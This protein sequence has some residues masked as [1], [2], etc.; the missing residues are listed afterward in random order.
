M[1]RK[2]ERRGKR[3]LVIDIRY[4]KKDGTPARYRKD[5]QVQMVPAATAEERRLLANIAQY[6]DV[7]EPKAEVPE[8]ATPT[9]PTTW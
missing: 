2:E 6:G 1:I 3:I 4:K 5:A 9:A 8:E 7:Y